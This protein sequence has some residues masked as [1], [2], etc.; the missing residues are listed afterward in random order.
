MHGYRIEGYAQDIDTTHIVIHSLLMHVSMQMLLRRYSS[1]KANR[2]QQRHIQITQ[3]MSQF[4]QILIQ[5]WKQ[6]YCDSYRSLCIVIQTVS[7]GCRWYPAPPFLG[8]TSTT[9]SWSQHTKKDTYPPPSLIQE[10]F[11]VLKLLGKTVITPMQECFAK[12]FTS[13]LCFE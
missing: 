5:A 9:E 7:W 10:H 3:C 2:W 13:S 11:I 6:V 1:N 12:K 4:K 8:S